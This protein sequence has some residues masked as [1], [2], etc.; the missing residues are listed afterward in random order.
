MFTFTELYDLFDSIEPY[1]REAWNQI[2][3]LD[4]RATIANA[5]SS[6]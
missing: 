4:T 2:K 1:S 3:F 5:E 6:V